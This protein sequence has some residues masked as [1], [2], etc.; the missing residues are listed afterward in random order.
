MINFKNLNRAATPYV[1]IVDILMIFLVLGNLSW[2]IFDALFSVSWFQAG[3]N[4]LSSSF[5]NWYGV[6]VH[7]NF[8]SYDLIFVAIYLTEFT[9]GWT[10]S[11]I[12]KRYSNW[13]MYPLLHWYD[14]LGCIPIGSF[15]FLRILRVISIGARLQRLGIIDVKQWSVFRFFNRYYNI[16]VE[17]V[18]DRVVVN[19]LNGVQDELQHG[20][21]DVFHKLLNRVLIPQQHILVD[22]TLNH[23]GSSVVKVLNQNRTHLKRYISSL[24]HDALE[25]NTELRR[26]GWLPVLGNTVN[27]Q[28]DSAISDIV[29]SIVQNVINDITSNKMRKI[30]GDVTLETLNSIDQDGLF[31]NENGIE[32]VDDIINLIKEQVLI[33][34]WRETDATDDRAEVEQKVKQKSEIGN[35]Q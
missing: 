8:E 33:Q 21:D 19:V 6:K 29:N 14:I 27:S 12:T 4:V 3:L 24:V 17:E 16:I 7:P 34:R 9:I 18:S 5:V 15:R 30:S 35:Q 28:L 32:L 26:I 23:V 20:Q 1:L 25:R 10:L 13:F 11:I 2:I 22:A 31:S